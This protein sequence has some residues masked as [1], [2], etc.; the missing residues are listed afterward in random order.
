MTRAFVLKSRIVI[1]LVAWAALTLASAPAGATG[2]RTDPLTI[3]ARIGGSVYELEA[4]VVRPDD[5]ASH[6]LALLD[7]GSPR[8]ARER[9]KQNPY[10]MWRQAAEFARRGWTAVPFMRRGYGKSEGAWAETYGGCGGPDYEAAGRA[11]AED[12][13]AAAKFM[14]TEPYVAKGKWISVG[15]SAG[16]YATVALTAASPPGLAAALAFAPGRGSQGPN[17]VCAE[18]R[19][20]AAFGRYGKTARTPLLW[21]SA[22]N[23]LFFG[24]A[25]VARALGAYRAG[26]GK[27]DFVA[28]PAYGS[29]GHFLFSQPGGIPIWT[30]IVDRF[31]ESQ[32]LQLRAT[33]IELPRPNVAP[34][35][36][37]DARGRETFATY[38]E[39]GPNKAF[40]IGAGSRFGWATGR[41]SVEEARAAALGFCAGIASTTCTVVNINNRPS[42]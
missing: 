25:L 35:A 12:I 16:A 31:L 18:G 15:V 36:G 34:P 32:G 11:G 22:P 3:H 9:P 21:V 27:A 40:A 26:G 33:P 42:R 6:P 19:L 14:E 28:A 2:I 13:A 23:D 20:V 24:P 7:H 39:S 5:G 17:S 37:L 29:D 8:D 4:I 41:R 10:G 1:A 30:P 38:L